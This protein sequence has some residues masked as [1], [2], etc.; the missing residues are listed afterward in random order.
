[1]V[2]NVTKKQK[3]AQKLLTRRKEPLPDLSAL[4]THP[5]RFLAAFECSLCAGCS[6]RLFLCSD[7]WTSPGG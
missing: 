2:M 3:M 7:S 6:P 4:L 1:M 5:L